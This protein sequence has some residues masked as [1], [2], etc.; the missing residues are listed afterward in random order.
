MCGLDLKV[1]TRSSAYSTLSIVK[2]SWAL[3]R[4]GRKAREAGLREA[5]DEGIFVL[6]C[7][8]I[9]LSSGLGPVVEHSALATA[10]IYWI[11]GIDRLTSRAP[12]EGSPSSG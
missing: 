2:V 4:D 5:L 12:Q 1:S 9:I 6:D 10:C 3:F 7:S 11:E 8:T